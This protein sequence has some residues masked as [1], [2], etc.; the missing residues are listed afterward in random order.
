MSHPKDFEEVTVCPYCEMPT[1]EKQTDDTGSLTYCSE[2]C[3]CL[4]GEDRLPRKYECPK[5]HELKDE[6]KCDCK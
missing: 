4:E 1:V 2:G 6:P 5:C 3:G